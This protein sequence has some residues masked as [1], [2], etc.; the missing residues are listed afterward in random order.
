MLHGQSLVPTFTQGMGHSTALLRSICLEMYLQRID[1][2]AN[3]IPLFKN[4]CV[5]QETALKT[6]Y[7][8]LDSMCETQVA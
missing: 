3:F 7:F 8:R 1:T 6:R 5:V 4:D 2:E